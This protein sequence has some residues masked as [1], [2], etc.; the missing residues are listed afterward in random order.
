MNALSFLFSARARLLPAALGAGLLL[1]MPLAR[2]DAYA[3]VQ[4][5]HQAG[6]TQ[7]ALVQADAYIAKRPNDPQM[8]FVKANVLSASGRT[9]QAQALLQQLTLDYPE[10]PE[11]WNNLA[12]LY[13]GRGDLGQAQEALEAA[14]RVNPA[15]VTALENLADVRLRQALQALQRAAQASPEAAQR[16]ASRVQGVQSLLGPAP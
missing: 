11:P 8:R 5:L 2:A 6:Q 3:D 13:A 7:Q 16:L 1:A 10:L 9:E 12:V 14:L 15:Y 4:K